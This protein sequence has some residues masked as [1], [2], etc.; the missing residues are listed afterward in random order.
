[1]NTYKPK[2]PYDHRPLTDEMETESAIQA[3]KSFFHTKFADALNLTYVS[4]PITVSAD[5]GINDDLD[6]IMKAVGFTLRDD[7]THRVEIVQSLA[8][9]KRMALAH[10]G[11]RHGEGLFTNMIAIRADEKID[12]IHSIYV[13]QWDWERV[14]ND[15]ERNLEFLKDIV[16]CIYEVIKATENHIC[17]QYRSLTATLPEEIAFVHSEDLEREYPHLTPKE[18]EDIV[19][20]EYGAVFL[21][22]IGAAL[23]SGQPHEDRAPDYDDWT[24]PTKRAKRGLNGDILVWNPVFEK[25]FELSS[26]GVRV[27]PNALVRQLRLAG[28]VKRSFLPIHLPEF[29]R[30][31]LNYELP[32]SIGGGIG[33]SRLCMLLLRK[34]HIGEVQFS[35]WPDSMRAEYEKLGIRLR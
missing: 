10:F 7:K 5:T 18:R 6:G 1:M 25:A 35:V 34:A 21:I 30:K 24:T 23:A 13:D 32:L 14:I 11:F 16:R 20:K 4:G 17:T 2:L 12:S 29:H 15:E 27:D 33:Q 19:T 22:G 9:W 8:K 31:L 28:R 3:I 26:M